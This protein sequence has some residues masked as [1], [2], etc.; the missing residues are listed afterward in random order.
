MRTNLKIKTVDTA[1]D[2]NI[3]SY[4]SGVMK[5]AILMCHLFVANS[6]PYSVYFHHGKYKT[7]NASLI[8]MSNK[9][10]FAKILFHPLIDLHT[11]DVMFNQT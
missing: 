2:G 7:D 1:I 9:N 4:L 6:R 8:K 10:G 5:I 3:T 11:Y